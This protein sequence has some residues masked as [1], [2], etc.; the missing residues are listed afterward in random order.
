MSSTDYTPEVQEMV[1]LLEYDLLLGRNPFEIDA[2][3]P[4]YYY[5]IIHTH[6]EELANTTWEDSYNILKKR[7]PVWFAHNVEVA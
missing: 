5:T 1:R 3:A 2:S 6:D 7:H 4:Q